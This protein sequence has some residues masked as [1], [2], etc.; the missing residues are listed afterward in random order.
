MLGS[1]AIVIH[2][3]KQIVLYTDDSDDDRVAQLDRLLFD[4]IS[5]KGRNDKYI[6]FVMN[7]VIITKVHHLCTA[8]KGKW[9]PK[10]LTKIIQ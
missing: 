2:T 10:I 9:T 1:W 5:K 3:T 6:P 8:P 7:M 4:Q